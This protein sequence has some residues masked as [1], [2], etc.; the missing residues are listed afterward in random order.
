MS[1]AD[2]SAL[3]TGI[4]GVIG[5]ITAL[6]IAINHVLHHDAPPADGEPAGSDGGGQSAQR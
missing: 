4:T 6:V 5:A 2:I 1:A 3:A